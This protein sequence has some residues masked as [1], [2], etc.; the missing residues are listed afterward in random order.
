[1]MSQAKA[2]LSSLVDALLPFAQ[3]GVPIVGRARRSHIRAITH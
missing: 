3:A 2:K 1:M